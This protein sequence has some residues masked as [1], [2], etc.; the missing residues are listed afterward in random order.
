MARE[1]LKAARKAKGLTQQQMAEK[2]G[3]TERHYRNIE[4]GAVIGSIELWD[5]ME[6]MFNVHQRIL[7]EKAADN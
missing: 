3:I 7:R 1:N 4:T 6:D 2:L 5:K